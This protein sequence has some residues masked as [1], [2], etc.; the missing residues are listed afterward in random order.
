[1]PCAP[2]GPCGPVVPTGPCEPFAPAGPLSTMSIA[3]AWLVLVLSLES[4]N[5]DVLRAAPFTDNRIPLFGVPLSQACTKLVTSAGTNWLADA[6]G[7]G[8]GSGGQLAGHDPNVSEFS[9]QVPVTA[10]TS[11]MPGVVT[12]LTQRSNVARATW[13]AGVPAGSVERSNLR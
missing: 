1:G 3:A 11:S 5:T 13:L 10:A 12:R 8:G 4:K 2:V 9:S 6:I 7:T